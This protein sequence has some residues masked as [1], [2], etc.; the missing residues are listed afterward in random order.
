MGMLSIFSDQVSI[1]FSALKQKVEEF[2]LFSVYEKSKSLKVWQ[3]VKS[4]LKNIK[5]LRSLLSI[6]LSNIQWV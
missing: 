4:L 5:H 1:S 2:K 3:K 6:I